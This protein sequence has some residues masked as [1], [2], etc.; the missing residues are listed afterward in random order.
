[1]KMYGAMEVWLHSFLITALGRDEWYS[2]VS[3]LISIL[4][5]DDPLG[6]KHV[7]VSATNTVVLTVII[8]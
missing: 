8:I 3:V 2:L 1:M 4:P 5:D 7:A 6:S